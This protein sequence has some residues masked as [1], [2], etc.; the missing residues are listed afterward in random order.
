MGI[1]DRF[2]PGEEGSAATGELRFAERWSEKEI[3]RAVCQNSLQK[4]FRQSER[5]F[6]RG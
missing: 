6:L 3:W 4:W 5:T 1:N 2:K